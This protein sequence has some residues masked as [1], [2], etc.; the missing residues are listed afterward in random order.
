MLHRCNCGRYTDLGALCLSCSVSKN[1]QEIEDVDI[2]DFIEPAEG[3]E[4]DQ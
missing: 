4:E 1:T 3:E 2:E